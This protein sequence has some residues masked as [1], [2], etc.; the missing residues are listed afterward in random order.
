M[1]DSSGED[2]AVLHGEGSPGTKGTLGV[3]LI[4]LTFQ[5][6]QQENIPER[7]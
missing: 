2:P 5:S 3:Q 6:K 1:F 7:G 4:W